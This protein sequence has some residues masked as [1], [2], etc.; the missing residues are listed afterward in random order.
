LKK[1]KNPDFRVKERGLNDRLNGAKGGG[2]NGKFMGA[3]RTTSEREGD[4]Y[5]L[6]S[7]PWPGCGGGGSQDDQFATNNQ[8]VSRARDLGEN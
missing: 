5:G 1:E 8:E 2:E 3:V 4:N 6:T 7:A